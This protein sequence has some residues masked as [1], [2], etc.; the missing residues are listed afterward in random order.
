[1]VQ[2][3]YRSKAVT[4]TSLDGGP[5]TL[6]RDVV[7]ESHKSKLAVADVPVK[8]SDIE[9][10]AITIM[11]TP[12]PRHRLPWWRW[13]LPPAGLQFE[14]GSDDEALSARCSPISGA[15]VL[16]GEVS[17]YPDQHRHPPTGDTA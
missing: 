6:S 4:P 16:L 9:L 8:L 2:S 1:M 13:P 14:L 12:G 3:H 11:Q 15:S 17:P 7:E 5:I 10:W